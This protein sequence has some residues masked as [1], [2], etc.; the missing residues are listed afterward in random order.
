MQW[1]LRDVQDTSRTGRHARL[2][3]TMDQLPEKGSHGARATTAGWEQWCRHVWP[4]HRYKCTMHAKCAICHALPHAHAV[5]QPQAATAQSFLASSRRTAPVAGT[6]SVVVAVGGRC[7]LAVPASAARPRVSAFTIHKRIA[8]FCS[9]P[10]PLQNAR[11]ASGRSGR[12]RRCEVQHR[13]RR[14]N[15]HCF[16]DYR[17]LTLPTRRARRVFAV[18]GSGFLE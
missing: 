12:T 17:H 10:R 18:W 16:S 7:R 14:P 11:T 2:L 9:G 15:R 4:A 5:P 13:S 8:A 3:S 1:R 6:R